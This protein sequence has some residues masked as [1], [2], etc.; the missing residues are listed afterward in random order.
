MTV[1]AMRTSYTDAV[2]ALGTTTLP[3][4]HP[5]HP[6]SILMRAGADA[7]EDALTGCKSAD[8]AVRKYCLG[9]LDHFADDACE[10]AIVRG[11]ADDYADVRRWAAHAISCQ[12]CKPRPLTLD[13]PA[14]LIGL[15]E[16]DPS[17]RVRRVAACYLASYAYDGR[18]REALTRVVERGT[19]AK[20]LSRAKHA[21]AWQPPADAN[22]PTSPAAPSRPA[23]GR[24]RGPRW[25]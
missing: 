20:L 15:L 1:T 4:G 22:C 9:F 7:I 14:L 17:A 19:D 2:A 25:A 3:W 10:A 6:M 23:A 16:N 8:R 11:L 24:A 5:E 18:V 12:Q 21:L 13:I